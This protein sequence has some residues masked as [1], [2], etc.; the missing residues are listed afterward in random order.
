MI[1]FWRRIEEFFCDIANSKFVFYLLPTDISIV[2]SLDL[3][4][5]Y[6]LFSGA[7][8]KPWVDYRMGPSPTLNSSV[9]LEK[10]PVQNQLKQWMD[11][12]YNAKRQ[13]TGTRQLADELD[14]YRVGFPERRKICKYPRGNSKILKV[15]STT[16]VSGTLGEVAIYY[17]PNTSHIWAAS[18]THMVGHKQT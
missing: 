17:R 6:I 1:I 11:T 3:A 12:T 8:R 18:L 14:H 5:I 2:P 4:Q 16:T 10:H 9:T 13:H 15:N 7:N